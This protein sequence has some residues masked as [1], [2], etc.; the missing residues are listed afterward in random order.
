VS[1]YR[2]RALR[3]ARDSLLGPSGIDGRSFERS[4]FDLEIPTPEEHEYVRFGRAKLEIWADDLIDPSARRMLSE[5]DFRQIAD[6]LNRIASSKELRMAVFPTNARANRGRP[7]AHAQRDFLLATE[8]WIRRRLNEE[9]RGSEYGDVLDTANAYK[10]AG[11]TMNIVR[12]ARKK[13]GAKS[14]EFISSY[15]AQM[16]VSP[17]K[18]SVCENLNYLRECVSARLLIYL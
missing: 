3:A 11:I 14:R 18:Y 10:R 13:W 5:G 12:H 1:A 15:L 7:N 2:E 17:T 8:Y 16:D 6:V 4:V 9:K